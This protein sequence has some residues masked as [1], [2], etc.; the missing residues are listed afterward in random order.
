M[1]FG[2]AVAPRPPIDFGTVM[3]NYMQ[4]KERQ[5]EEEAAE[6]QRRALLLSGIGAMY[7]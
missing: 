1:A 5:A 3:A 2:D 7:G 6:Q 4:R